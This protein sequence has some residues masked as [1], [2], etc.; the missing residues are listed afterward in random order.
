MNRLLYL[1]LITIL[2]SF[3]ANAQA[4]AA[5]D[6]LG[7]RLI[8]QL[9]K[10]DTSDLQTFRVILVTMDD[11]KAI[12]NQMEIPE[13]QKAEELSR[14]NEDFINQ[15]ARV[16]FEFLKDETE[17]AHINWKNIQYEDL[18]YRFFF[19][20]GMKQLKGNIYFKEGGAHYKMTID[21]GYVNG[22]FV[23]MQLDNLSVSED[24]EIYPVETIDQEEMRKAEEA[25]EKM[26][27]ELEEALEDADDE[28]QDDE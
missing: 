6:R 28:D 3:N 13:D 25:A 19:Y 1:S 18:L 27:R 10:I 23:V 16:N 26:V 22:E 20:Q 12:Y 5:A 7:E 2:F 4:G 9:K 11:V 17:A 8:Q 14:V 24:L 15:R 21:A